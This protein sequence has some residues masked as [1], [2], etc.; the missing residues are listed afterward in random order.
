MKNSFLFIVSLI[1]GLSRSFAA[2]PINYNIDNLLVRTSAV[3]RGSVDFSQAEVNQGISG[4]VYHSFRSNQFAGVWP[5][6]WVS[7]SGHGLF[8]MPNT[9]GLLIPLYATN[10]GTTNFGL[11]TLTGVHYDSAVVGNSLVYISGSN[12]PPFD[13][14]GMNFATYT[15]PNGTNALNGWG[16]N[17]LISPSLLVS[18]GALNINLKHYLHI[19]VSGNLDGS[20]GMSVILATNQSIQGV[21]YGAHLPQNIFARYG[22]N[23]PT[24]HNVEVRRIR[25]NALAIYVDGYNALQFSD[26]T[27]PLFWGTNCIWEIQGASVGNTGGQLSEWDKARTYIR[28]IYTAKLDHASRES[29]PTTMNSL[30]FDYSGDGSWRIKDGAIVNGSFAATNA[31]RTGTSQQ[32]VIGWDTFWNMVSVN[33]LVSSGAVRGS[34]MASVNG[35]VVSDLDSSGIL[36][37]AFG[38]KFRSNGTNNLE[39]NGVQLSIG[40]PTNNTPGFVN[41]NGSLIVTTN[42]QLY[43]R[44]NNVWRGPL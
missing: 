37:G 6:N 44:S 17:M 24:I 9:S 15:V 16:V 27:L 21:G 39:I 33:G 18:N 38:T 7:D 13:V 25:T 8:R 14:E 5:T 41:P 3:F 1:V 29:S 31:F 36:L 22:G 32:G 26:N 20:E 28:D 30:Q 35:L 40:V 2:T 23:P 43:I 11:G 19:G 12:F 34:S 10:Y 4:L 42:G